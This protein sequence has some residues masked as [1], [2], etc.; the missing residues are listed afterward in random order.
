VCNISFHADNVIV[1]Q[2]IALCTSLLKIQVLQALSFIQSEGL[3]LSALE[4]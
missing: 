2:N 3:Q 1:L 4:T